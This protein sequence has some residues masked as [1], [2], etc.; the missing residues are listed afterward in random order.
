MNTFKKCDA[1]NRQC[2]SRNMGRHSTKPTGQAVRA[3][4]S[5]TEPNGSWIGTVTFVDDFTREHSRPDLYL[6]SIEISGNF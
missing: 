3:N 2:A 1:N 5:E 6:A 4:S